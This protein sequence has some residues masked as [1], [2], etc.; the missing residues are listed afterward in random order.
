MFAS[1]NTHQID[2]IARG[3][4]FIILA[5]LGATQLNS[6]PVLGII[7]IVVG[8]V[9]LGTAVVGFCPIYAALGMNTNKA[10]K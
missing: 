9:L 3:V 4:L 5:V 10:E 2:R 1:K 7:L 8:L 6:S